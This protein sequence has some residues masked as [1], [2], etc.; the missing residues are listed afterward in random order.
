MHRAEN[1]STCA[2]REKRRKGMERKGSREREEVRVRLPK[3]S[4]P[5]QKNR[6]LFA[7]VRR[8]GQVHLKI[9]GT[10]RTYSTCVQPR[11]GAFISK[12]LHRTTIDGFGRTC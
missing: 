6:A 4:V 8:V 1:N 7:V 12:E 2:D 5:A 11:Q 3:S 9:R 10:S